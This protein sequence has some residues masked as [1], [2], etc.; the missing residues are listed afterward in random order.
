M[1]RTHPGRRSG[2]PPPLDAAISDGVVRGWAVGS[3]GS[4]GGLA[5]TDRQ[6]INY[7]RS[8]HMNIRASGSTCRTYGLVA[9]P[10]PSVR[11][12]PINPK[13]AAR[14]LPMWHFGLPPLILS[15]LHT[16]PKV[17]CSVPIPPTTITQDITLNAQGRVLCWTP[18]LK[19]GTSHSCGTIPSA[20]GFSSVLAFFA[21]A[22]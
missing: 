18:R 5:P 3:V 22:G 7:L 4:R 20:C 12:G 15:V 21:R 2:D 19:P 10:Y 17:G 13:P 1:A 8:K 14:P 16:Q 9:A 6:L 11:I